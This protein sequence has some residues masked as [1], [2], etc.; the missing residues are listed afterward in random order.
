MTSQSLS[1][2]SAQP[3]A[4]TSPSKPRGRPMCLAG[5]A[6]LRSDRPT[7]SHTPLVQPLRDGRLVCDQVP[8]AVGA[9][10]RLWTMP[11][12]LWLSSGGPSLARRRCALPCTRPVFLQSGS[13]RGGP[14]AALT[15]V[16]GLRAGAEAAGP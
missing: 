5:C 12:L 6:S 8:P 11:P 10:G 16:C 3:G 2:R 14:R 4:N 1:R 7:A 13:R 9:A 15:P